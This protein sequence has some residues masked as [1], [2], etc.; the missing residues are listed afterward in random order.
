[1]PELQEV[2]FDPVVVHA[3]AVAL[4]VVLIIGGAV[5]LRDLEL[6][7]HAVENYRMLGARGAV[8]FA[9]IYAVA[10][11][12]AGLALVCEATRPIGV[13]L[14]MAVIALATGAVGVNLLRG[15]L[16]IECG[17]GIGGQRISWGLVARNLVLLLAI[18]LAAADDS[19][20][21][22]GLVDCY[23]VAV[24]VLALLVLYASA[25]QLLANQP[26]LKELQS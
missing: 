2:L 14:A 9:P 23:S 4:A 11:L 12:T 15:R 24:A 26:L 7:R 22:L 10:E 20:R 25:N 5:K 18:M 21:P 16:R 19:R 3:V 1:M 17:C 6:F 13:W 8:G